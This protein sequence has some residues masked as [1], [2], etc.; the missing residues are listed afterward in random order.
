MKYVVYFA[1]GWCVVLAGGGE[2]M[3]AIDGNDLLGYCK[4]FLAEDNTLTYVRGV[5]YGLCMGFVSGVSEATHVW[6]QVAET[7][8]LCPPEGSPISQSI[9]IVVKALEDNPAVLHLS[10]TVLVQRALMDAFPCPEAE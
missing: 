8:Y 3:A 1:I 9:Q 10:A 6:Q 7:N 4:T 2:A 5:E